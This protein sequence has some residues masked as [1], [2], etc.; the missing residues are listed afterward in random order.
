MIF[1]FMMTTPPPRLPAHHPDFKRGL[2]SP[3]L[4]F[5]PGGHHGESG[6]ATR[7][8]WVAAGG[9][10]CITNQGEK[11]GAALHEMI[12]SLAHLTILLDFSFQK[13]T[14]MKL[15]THVI[16]FINLYYAFLFYT[17]AQLAVG[18]F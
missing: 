3:E 7:S 5:F 14:L 12:V 9:G 15:W 1:F 6:G 18:Y 8:L 17:Y 11:K 10:L 13:N 2:Q 16:V 4:H